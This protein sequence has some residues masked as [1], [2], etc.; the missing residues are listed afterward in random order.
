VGRASS[1]RELHAI[2][3]LVI[4]FHQHL[5]SAIWKIA[6]VS[7]DS[8]RGSARRREHP[9]ADALHAAADEHTTRDDH[10]T[11]IL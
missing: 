6:C 1:Q 7:V 2:H 9:E 3:A 5:D 8:F 10:E 4:P 11:I